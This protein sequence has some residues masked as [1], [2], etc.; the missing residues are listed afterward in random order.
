MRTDKNKQQPW[1]GRCFL[2][3]SLGYTALSKTKFLQSF[4]RQ[5]FGVGG[6]IFGGVLGFK[7]PN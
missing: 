7:N 4:Q 2:P 3:L 5:D 1:A 6:H